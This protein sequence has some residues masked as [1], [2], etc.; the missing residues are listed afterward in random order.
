ML[1]DLGPVRAVRLARRN[2]RGI[3]GGSLAFI[4]WSLAYPLGAFHHLIFDRDAK[5][6]ALEADT[7]PAPAAARPNSANA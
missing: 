3:L 5:Q 1:A 7:A 2:R 6:P 4:G